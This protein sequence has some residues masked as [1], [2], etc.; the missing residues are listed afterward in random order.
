[1]SAD[2][3]ATAPMML[4]AVSPGTPAA[5]R[6]GASERGG[7]EP[8]LPALVGGNAFVEVADHGGQCFLAA[9]RS[10]VLVTSI[11]FSCFPP[12]LTSGDG[13]CRTPWPGRR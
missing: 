10:Q 8:D 2:N 1:M 12:T 9:D 6:A 4:S 3:G 5:V 7:D 11:P 13:G